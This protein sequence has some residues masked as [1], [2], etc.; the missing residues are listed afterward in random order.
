MSIPYGLFMGKVEYLYKQEIIDII[1]DPKIRQKYISSVNKGIAHSLLFKRKEF[2]HEEEVR[3]IVYDFHKQLPKD[4]THLILPNIDPSPLI[5]EVL[6]D[7]RFDKQQ[8]D[9]DKIFLSRY[10]KNIRKSELYSV[11]EV[12]TEISGT[13]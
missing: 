6:F 11:P 9:E 7:P 4:R 13:C 12:F 5:D 1:K 8:F 10:T 3:L 2:D